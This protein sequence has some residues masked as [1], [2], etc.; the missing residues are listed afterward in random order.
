MGCYNRKCS[1]SGL[2]ITYGDEVYLFPIFGN[3]TDGNVYHN[4]SYDFLLPPI[5]GE[6]NDYGSIHKIDEDF[7]KEYM[8]F[9]RDEY[10]IKITTDEEY[11]KI[12]DDVKL[13][14]K[15][16]NN[17]PYCLDDTDTTKA[18]DYL[19]A[20]DFAYVLDRIDV[21]WTCNIW[22]DETHKQREQD[23]LDKEI[24]KENNGE[25][26]FKIL[27][28]RLTD[29][30][31]VSHLS[32]EKNKSLNMLFIRKDILDSITLEDLGSWYTNK[33]S[34]EQNLI[35]NIKFTENKS[36]RLCEKYPKYNSLLYPLYKASSSL[37]Q[38]YIQILPAV[39]GGQEIGLSL[40]KKINNLSKN[41]FD[42]L[43][44]RY[45]EDDE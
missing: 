7:Y 39:Y 24:M 13:T 35:E 17:I 29:E 21:R 10:N 33:Y 4:E 45:E 32:K 3:W 44:E 2:P 15:H 25:I 1:L 18:T 16:L 37:A 6:Y 27:Y 36:N 22:Y 40:Y 31:R 5:I 11:P 26:P 28:K 34:D 12:F 41:I 20:E 43:S 19:T 23:I 42:E 30:F 9:L 38:L 14:R 8:L